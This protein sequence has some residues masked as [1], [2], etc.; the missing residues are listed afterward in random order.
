MIDNDMTALARLRAM[1][2][3]ATRG[4]WTTTSPQYGAA[5]HEVRLGP[6]TL[7]A[8][9]SYKD[10]RLIATMRNVASD[11]L[12]IIEAHNEQCV[13]RPD[14]HYRRAPVI[15]RLSEALRRL[16]EKLT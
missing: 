7:A 11:L 6:C 1:L 3:E 9:G 2:A 16:E 5:F 4:E 8:C 13:I 15:A 12:D 14:D 10:A